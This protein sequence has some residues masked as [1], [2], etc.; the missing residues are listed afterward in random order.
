[1]SE[2]QKTRRWVRRHSND[3]YATVVASPTGDDQYV[4][5]V[6]DARFWNDGSWR[7]PSVHRLGVVRGLD[8][9]K[10]AA[11]AAAGHATCQCPDWTEE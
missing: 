2:Q 1:M 6:T 3:M 8:V 7:Q 4:P 10:Q 11:N 9:A 5:D